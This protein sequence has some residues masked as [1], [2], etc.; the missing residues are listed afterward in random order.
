MS[1]NHF[2]ENVYEVRVMLI[3]KVEKREISSK[4]HVE[5]YPPITT[6]T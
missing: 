2:V 6:T 4:L 3:P 5:D 1:R